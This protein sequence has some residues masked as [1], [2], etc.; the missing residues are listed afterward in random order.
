MP[1]FARN[2]ELGS[3]FTYLY[4]M[5]K[6]KG[7]HV[8]IITNQHNTTL[9]VGVTSALPQRVL[10]H[11]NKK[12]PKSFTA[13]YNL[14]KLVYYEFHELIMS[15]IERENQL[16]AG[17]RSKKEDLINGMNPEWRDLYDDIKDW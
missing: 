11:K 1:A 7:G 8:Y 9:Y 16:K 6:A 2:D 10:D 15:G 5:S 13:R 17:S 3:V 12:Y 14:N 4:T